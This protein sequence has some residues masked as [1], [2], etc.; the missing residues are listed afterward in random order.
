MET[1]TTTTPP[2]PLRP[3]RVAAW[4]TIVLAISA[5]LCLADR[6]V[7]AL[8]PDD[9]EAS[10]S[11]RFMPVVRQIVVGPGGLYGPFGG[12]NPYVLIH[13]PLYYRIAAIL[14]WPLAR[15]GLDP[16]FASLIAG[17]GVS[18]AAF[19]FTLF[20]VGRIARLGESSRIAA[21]LALLLLAALP[22]VDGLPITVSSDMLG[23]AF[24]T[25]GV[26]LTLKALEPGKGGRTLLI[27][28][29]LSFGLAVCVKQT[30]V[31][32]PLVSTILLIA[33]QVRGRLK[34][35]GFGQALLI[36]LAVVSAN[37][38]AEWW[39][40]AGRVF[41]PV[42][43]V[44]GSLGR[45]RPADW[46]RA[47]ALVAEV[48]IWSLGLLALWVSAMLAVVGSKPGKIR[49]AVT[50]AGSIT[51]LTVLILA[52]LGGRER[53]YS[54]PWL[55]GGQ[56]AI[57]GL[58]LVCILIEPRGVLGHRVDAALWIYG[59]SEFA[60][61]VALS[62]SSTGAWTNYAV[63]ALIFATILTARCLARGLAR[64]SSAWPLFAPGF[65]VLAVLYLALADISTIHRRRAVDLSA[66]AALLER[67][68]RD[69]RTLY[70]VGQPGL[71]RV[72]G[73]P[74][75]VCDDWLYP[76]FE[77]LRL[78]DRRSIW[79]GAALSPSS[80]IRTVVS[81]APGSHLDGLD[82]GLDDLGFH[83]SFHVGPF[84]VWERGPA[85]LTPVR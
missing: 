84:Y 54:L 8:R 36:A 5:A 59:I 28:A 58:A 85:R 63:P 6:L 68:D 75:L 65:A 71:N 42:F 48:A 66:R 81:N 19:M 20:L 49:F 12:G 57:V 27:G 15:S 16:V 38:G 10:E 44:A 72:L 73:R 56:A 30:Y 83:P 52:G 50:F 51:L 29:Y 80:P 77:S 9:T 13:A 61:T 37:F 46:S 34:S 24:Q 25:L 22:V 62:R 2:K 1:T 23:I 11:L 69:P 14:A 41:E 74:E 45:L 17:R 39:L 78:A 31:V 21:W 76:V 79:L 67:V 4:L 3:H 47:A 18:F 32:T 35:R 26:L 7:L 43:V 82:V 53:W 60:L 64:A 33:A 70:F 40:T 55:V